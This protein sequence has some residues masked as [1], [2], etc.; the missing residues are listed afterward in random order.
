MIDTAKYEECLKHDMIESDLRELATE[1]IAE[2][3]RMRESIKRILE[4]HNFPFILSGLKQELK[5]MI[6]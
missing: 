4:T 3:K 5:E 1:L 2:V 6:K